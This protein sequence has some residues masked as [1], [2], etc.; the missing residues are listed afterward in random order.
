MIGILAVFARKNALQNLLAKKALQI[1]S[2]TF[3][4]YILIH[5]ATCVRV[6]VCTGHSN[7]ET[8]KLVKD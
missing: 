4:Q 7:R 3:T 8:T 2:K 6:S 5:E 1:P